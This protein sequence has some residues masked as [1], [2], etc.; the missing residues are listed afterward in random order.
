MCSSAR[1]ANT[2]RSFEGEPTTWHD[3]FARY[4]LVMDDQTLVIASF[5]PPPGEGFAV[6]APVKGQHRCVVVAPRTPAPGNPWSW[7]GCYWDHEPQTEIE[8]LHR[9]YHVAYISA[10]ASLKPDATW[11]AW[12]RFLTEDHRL[13]TRPA[14]IGMSRGGEYAYTWAVRHPD[15]VASIYADNPGGNDEMLAGLVALARHDV[16]L[17]HVCGSLDPILC[18]FSNAIEGIYQQLGGRISVMIK[19]GAGHH[20]HSLRDAKPIADWIE[21]NATPRTAS[22]PDFV[23]PSARQTAF[24]GVRAD[25][26]YYPTE[27]RFI[28][29]RGPWFTGEYDRYTFNVAGI[30]GA[31]TVILPMTQAPGRPWVFRAGY[32]DGRDAI[33]LALLARGFAIVTGP[34]SFNSD[35]LKQQ[36]WDATYAHLIAHGFSKMPVLQGTSRGAGEVLAWAVANPG[37]LSAIYVEN[38]V[39]QSAMSTRPPLDDLAMLTRANVALVQVS[40]GLDPSFHENAGAA[41]ERYRAA[42]GKSALIVNESE[43]HDLSI[44]AHVPE[45]LSK[46]LATSSH[47]FRE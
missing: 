23:G 30:D 13:S 44:E 15:A 27:G 31:I 47:A 14:F 24:Y 12:Y 17:L 33:D 43:S 1:A 32:P 21:A 11:D 10:D 42:G 19:D 25:A 34:V 7:R 6:G 37:K 46:I 20:P 3:G 36:D 40:G 18:Q 4:D 5:R 22:A 26:V 16:P 9:G 35:K 41:D 39:Y 45:I 2:A 28:A 38:P 29:C 8:L